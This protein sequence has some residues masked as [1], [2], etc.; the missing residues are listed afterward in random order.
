MHILKYTKNGIADFSEKFE[1]QNYAKKEL[2][3]NCCVAV[4]WAVGGSVD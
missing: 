3:V 4:L 1:T 2:L